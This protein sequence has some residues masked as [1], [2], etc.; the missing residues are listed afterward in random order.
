M[1]HNYQN[2]QETL[3]CLKELHKN[4]SSPI[5]DVQ[6]QTQIDVDTAMNPRNTTNKQ[7]KSPNS[8]SDCLLIHLS[9]HPFGC[10]RHGK[11][12]VFEIKNI[13]RTYKEHAAYER[14][15]FTNERPSDL[16]KNKWIS[17]PSVSE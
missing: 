14:E 1:L 17:I 6:R 13:S 10:R 7:S 15:R 12:C 4:S 3:N 2:I 8:K 5:E 16:L 9:S 11:P